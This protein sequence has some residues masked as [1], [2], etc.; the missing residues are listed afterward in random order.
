VLLYTR[1]SAQQARRFEQ[2]GA[3]PPDELYFA[4][5]PLIEGA[6]ADAVWVAIEVPDAEAAVFETVTPPDLGYREF[7]LDGSDA[8][9][10]RVWRMDRVRER[11]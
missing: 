4:D 10:Y 9:R 7:V 3:L 6:A 5:R 2:G 8:A 1:L 11:P